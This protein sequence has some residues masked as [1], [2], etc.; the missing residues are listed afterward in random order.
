M[1]QQLKDYIEVNRLCSELLFA[2]WNE[3]LELLYDNGSY[4]EGV[5]W[6]EYVK[7]SEQKYSMGTGG[8]RDKNNPEYMYAETL[9]YNTDFNNNSLFEIKE[10][11]ESILEKYPRNLLLPSFCI[12]E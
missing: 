9:I 6:F 5:V 11:I 12:K 1:T 10:Y 3:F 4:V 2:D 7:V 8:Y